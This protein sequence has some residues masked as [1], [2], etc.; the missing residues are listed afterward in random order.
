MANKNLRNPA[1]VPGPWYVDTTCIDCGMCAE[2]A[3]MVFERINGEDLQRVHHQPES[4]ESLALADESK[5]G[6]PVDAIGSDGE[7]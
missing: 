3:P 1:N 7:S 5:E 6:C 2:I 4:P